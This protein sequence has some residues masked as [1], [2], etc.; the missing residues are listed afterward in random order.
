MDFEHDHL[1]ATALAFSV[2]RGWW[3]EL[4]DTA[5]SLQCALVAGDGLDLLDGW[6][7][8]ALADLGVRR[9]SSWRL[10]RGVF[11]FRARVTV[12]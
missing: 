11:A 7:D 9:S 8:D 1:P 6:V 2:G 3:L 10:A 4:E 12:R 5:G